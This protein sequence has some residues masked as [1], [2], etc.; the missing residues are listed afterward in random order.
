[1]RSEYAANEALGSSYKPA[2]WLQA[3]KGYQVKKKRRAL[4]V[5]WRL[6]GL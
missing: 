1:M 5:L 2:K 3:G 4:P 6:L